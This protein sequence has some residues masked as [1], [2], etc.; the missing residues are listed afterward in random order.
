[1][2]ND[3]DENATKM[4]IRSDLVWANGK[5]MSDWTN[6][7]AKRREKRV[8][9]IL[10][11]IQWE[12]AKERECVILHR[13]TINLLAQSL[14]IKTTDSSD[15]NWKKD[16]LT[17]A[18]WIRNHWWSSRFKGNQHVRATMMMMWHFPCWTFWPKRRFLRL[19]ECGEE[20]ER[21]WWSRRELIFIR[22]LFMSSHNR[23]F[24]NN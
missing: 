8:G 15:A 22:S 23:P 24:M 13:L 9:L 10:P 4:K 16:E 14:F 5:S 21:K 18:K 11:L 1:M 12:R 20:S 3:S 19:L 6:E 2:I 7:R 17:A